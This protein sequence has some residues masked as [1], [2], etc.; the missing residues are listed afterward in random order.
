REDPMRQYRTGFP[1]SVVDAFRWLMPAIAHADPVRVTGGIVDTP[2]FADLSAATLLGDGLRLTGE[3]AG[4]HLGG[5]GA[6]GTMG[7]LDGTFELF[8]IS[9]ALPMVVNGTAYRALLDGDL[10]FT[11]EP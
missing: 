9:G 7:N 2:F 8:P 10:T 6:V 3:G 5:P 1:L 11:T 4:S